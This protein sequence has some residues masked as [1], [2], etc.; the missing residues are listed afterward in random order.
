MQ[1]FDEFFVEIALLSLP[2]GR[3]LSVGAILTP[4]I[5]LIAP[6]PG[7]VET[8][9]EMNLTL[10]QALLISDLSPQP[11]LLKHQFDRIFSLISSS[12]GR[13]SFMTSASNGL[14]RLKDEK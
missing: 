11:Q 1:T 8:E 13:D 4:Y 14:S 5:R 6:P 7:A 2:T 12:E 10:K 9:D 3:T